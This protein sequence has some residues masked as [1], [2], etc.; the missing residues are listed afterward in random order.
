MQSLKK[1]C[2]KSCCA[3]VAAA[4]FLIVASAV[5][6]GQTGSASPVPSPSPSPSPAR[7]GNDALPPTEGDADEPT[8]AKDAAQPARV[9]YFF[10]DLAPDATTFK[11]KLVDLRLGF[12]ILTDYTVVGQNSLSRAQVGPQAS[13]FDLRSGRFLLSGKINFKRP[14][15]FSIAGDYDEHRDRGDRLFDFVD[16]A[17]TIPLWKK[18]RIT[19]GKQ[20]E[21]F[22]FEVIAVAAFLPQQERILNPFF[23]TRNVG[24]RYHDNYLKDKMSFS[25]GVFNDWFQS[26]LKFQESGFQVSGRLTGL[27]I[28]S[29]DHRTFLHLGVGLRYNGANQEQ[30]RFRGRPESNV[31]DNYVDTGNFPAKYAKQI[32]LEALYNRGSFSVLAEYTQ[33][34]VNSPVN[35]N[36]S[37]NGSYVTGSYFLTGDYR[38]QQK[39]RQH[40][41]DCSKVALGGR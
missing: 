16:W 25:V 40:R 13:V 7:K 34:W 1:S 21:P 24:I 3:L 15:S 18:A 14:W 4:A 19:L 8:P 39:D 9:D 32:A 35:G 41:L 33:A 37:F 28:E 17:V 31:I 5:G 10:P 12:A 38:L 36:P 26:D 23:A 27:P 22:I 6:F 11:T 29:Q 20:K 30:M 2:Y